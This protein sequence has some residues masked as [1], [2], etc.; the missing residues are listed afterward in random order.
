MRK[1][2]F[3][4]CTILFF[5]NCF[6]QDE[7]TDS[8]LKLLQK[9]KKDTTRVNILNQISLSYSN[10]SPENAIKY[11]T[12][13]KQLA[14]SI[15][16]TRGLAYAL[17][18][19]GIAYYSQADNVQTLA[20]WSQSLK[21][22]E[23]IN[24]KKGIANILS[25]LGAVY[26]NKGDD[27]NA[28]D[29]YNKSL[30]YA[31]ELN[32]TL[33][34][35]TA[36]I[37]MG[38][39][40]FNNPATHEKAQTYYLE[41][42][43]LCEKLGDNDAIGTTTVN[44]G[45]IYLA[46]NDDST[47]L[48][49]FERSLKAYENSKNIPYSLNDIARV[50]EKRGDYAT[51]LKY[52]NQALEAAEKLSAKL[53][54][55]Q[56]YLG[57][58]TTFS[59]KGDVPAALNAYN[60]GQVIAKEI[61]AYTELKN[62]Y[63]G[64]AKLY[65]R[66]GDLANAYKYQ[67]LLTDINDTIYNY[68]TEKKIAILEFNSEI[69]KKQTEIDLLTRDKDLQNLNLKRQAIV[70]NSLI[71][72]LLLVIVIVF[73]L[74]RNYLIK[75]KTN[76]L[77]DAQKKELERTLN[78]LKT[79]QTQLIQS[80]KMASLGDLTAGIA[81]EIQNPLNFI[82]NFSDVNKELLGELREEAERCNIEGIKAIMNDLTS[83]EE[84]INH[85]GKRADAI[86][87][88][89]LQ[90]SR[91]SS[92]RK[93]PTNINGLCE[94]CLR[95]S[96][97]G[98]RAKDKTFNAEFKTS[99]DNSIDKISVVSQDIVRVVLNLFNNAFYAVNEKKKIADKAYQPRVSVETK[100]LNGKIE[101]VVADNGDGIPQNITD[102]IFQPFFTTKPAGKGT[103]LGLSLAYDIITKEHNGTIKVESEEGKGSR[104]IIQLPA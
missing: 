79:T 25:N 26:F 55:A 77:L 50:Y 6:P 62:A 81:H 36:L 53:D 73:V 14:D 101:I 32:D 45:E 16:Y 96:Y 75:T 27:A 86:V 39:V 51:A 98:L 15:A 1:L 95:L 59:K 22:F 2:I 42:L 4:I 35:A 80:E 38:A 20:N 74:F 65:V 90:H 47:A 97:H 83:N 28:L 3:L 104:F 19:I 13:A 103:G 82:N 46:K 68:E 89:M 93:E 8:L 84:K 54:M 94:E 17:K 67:R 69:Q 61:G 63:D 85:H 102:K 24:D 71:A 100:K 60:Q 41:A 12:Q 58:A 91:K 87:K 72:V 52:H 78:D 23:E 7:Q 66:T 88:G 30:K 37:N 99:F 43:P 10:T 70:R 18:N 31:E 57:L 40:Y 44:L 5:G 76:A 33:R 49:Y 92:G 48:Y 21:A 9:T 34:I 56:S 11:G 64:L 29:Y